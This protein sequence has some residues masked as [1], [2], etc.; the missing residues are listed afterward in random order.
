LGYTSI[1]SSGYWDITDSVNTP[2]VVLVNPTNSPLW[3][4]WTLPD[5]NF[6]L[7]AI[8]SLPTNAPPGDVGGWVLPSRF[9]GYNITPITAER[10]GGTNWTLVPA[11]CLP[12]ADPSEYP[13][14]TNAYFNLTTNVPAN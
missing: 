8:A 13:G 1:T 11:S 6:G 10:A 4:V 2:G 7:E 9:N 14:A 12:S 3:L 5:V